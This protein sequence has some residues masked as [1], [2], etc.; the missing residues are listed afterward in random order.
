MTNIAVLGIGAMGSRLA[1]N[2]CEAGHNVT[3]W[4]RTA[5]TAQRLAREHEMSVADTPGDAVRDADVIVTMVSNDEAASAVWL[6]GDGV[7]RG[8][9][10]GT[11]AIES[12]T[13]TPGT[14]RRISDAASRSSVRFVEAPVVGSRPQAEARSLFYIL[15]GEPADLDEA[16][17]IIDVSAGKSTRVGPIG[18]AAALKLAIN[19]LF[20]AQVAAYAEIVGF[21]ERS[22]LA[23]TEA[24]ATLKSLPITSPGLERILGLIEERD[25]RPN[26]PIHL[27]AKDLAYL[28]DTA[29]KHNSETPLMAAAA[30]VFAQGDPDGSDRNLDI[31]GVARRYQVLTDPAR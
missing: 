29:G 4:N 21:I 1:A 30:A 11:I 31:A 27:V 9:K 2:Y 5:K 7:L 16:Q 26:F 13:L 6:D 10:P 18:N 25:Y 24:L 22:D 19:G 12:S 14:V 8:A 20:A 28:V 17:P 15:A 3:V 23:T